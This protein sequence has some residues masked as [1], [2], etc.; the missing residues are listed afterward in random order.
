[1]WKDEKIDC[2]IVKFSIKII[3]KKY[4]RQYNISVGESLLQKNKK[5]IL[6]SLEKN[7]Y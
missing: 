5:K 4:V 7:F 6:K 2:T 3:S 1:M